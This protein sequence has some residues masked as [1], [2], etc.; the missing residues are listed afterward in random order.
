M[1]AWA[2]E[3][4]RKQFQLPR[5]ICQQEVAHQDHIGKQFTVYAPSNL[6][7]VSD[8][9]SGTH[10][11]NSGRRRA[12]RCRTRAVDTDNENNSKQCHKV[13]A[14]THRESRNSNSESFQTSS[15]C[16]NGGKWT[17]LRYPCICCGWKQFYFFCREYSKPRNSQS[18]RLQSVLPDH[19]NVRPVTGIEEFKSARTSVIEVQVPSH[20]QEIRSLGC[21]YLEE[22]NKTHDN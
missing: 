22:L 1:T 7:V 21:E 9:K 14:T 18:S 13:G 8:S 11:K 16:L 17:I 6:P 20:T 2:L 15:F 4:R 10:T 3:E 19:V 12:N 5:Y